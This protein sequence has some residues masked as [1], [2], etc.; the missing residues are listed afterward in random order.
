MTNAQLT[1]IVR[2]A[3]GLNQAGEAALAAGYIA[4]T[5]SNHAYPVA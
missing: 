2:L 1:L 5:R 3:G 4:D